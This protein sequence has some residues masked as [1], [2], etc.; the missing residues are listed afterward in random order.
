MTSVWTFKFTFKCKLVLLLTISG[1]LHEYGLEHL[2]SEGE[3]GL[4]YSSL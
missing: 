4:G 3:G 1:D 2:P